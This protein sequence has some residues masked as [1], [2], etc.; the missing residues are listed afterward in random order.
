MISWV[1]SHSAA[2]QYYVVFEL[3]IVR[4][5]VIE[6]EMKTAAFFPA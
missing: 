1:H 4:F 6:C 3:S 5:R 2:T